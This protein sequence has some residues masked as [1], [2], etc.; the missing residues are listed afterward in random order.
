MPVTDGS[1]TLTLRAARTGNTI[2][3]TGA[4]EAKNW[5]LC[6]RNAVKVSGPQNGS[7]AES[8]QGLMVK[9]QGNAL[10]IAL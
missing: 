10:T 5:I 9:P 2:I 3:T 6:L 4:D 1:V 8:E 7:W